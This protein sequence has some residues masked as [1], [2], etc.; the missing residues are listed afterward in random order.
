MERWSGYS[1]KLLYKTNF[2]EVNIPDVLLFVKAKTQHMGFLKKR[3]RKK[4][5]Y[6]KFNFYIR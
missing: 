3:K 4:A 6:I 2:S 5:A 1:R